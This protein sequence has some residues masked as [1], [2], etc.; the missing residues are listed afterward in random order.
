MMRVGVSSSHS[1]LAPSNLEGHLLRETYQVEEKIAHGG[2]AWVY[3]ARHVKEGS[4]W[5]LKI[6]FPHH[7]EN[8]SIRERFLRESKIQNQLA[9]PN[10][11]RVH[12]PIREKNVFGYAMEW[13]NGNDLRL[14]LQRQPALLPMPVMASLF[15]GIIEGIS[16]AHTR[17]I[18]H[19]D[20]KPE[21]VL[22]SISNG[23][24]IPRI[25][26]FGIA[27]V[28]EDT[29]HTETGSAIGT[30]SYM[31][32]EQ[33][34]DAKTI[35]HRSDIY[36]LGVM[37]YYM[38]TGRLPF[39]FRK[40]T[41]QGFL[42]MMLKV[43]HEQPAVPVEAPAA[44]QPLIMKCLEKQVDARFQSCDELRHAFCEACARESVSLR[45]LTV[46]DLVLEG[47]PSDTSGSVGVSDTRAHS[48]SPHLV[49]V[50]VSAEHTPA[51]SGSHFVGMQ[52]TSA[53]P[54]TH[55]ELDSMTT[56]SPG[57]GGFWEHTSQ[58]LD[59]FEG[60]LAPAGGPESFP[61]GA[62]F[63]ERK[64]DGRLVAL[65]LAGALGMLCFVVWLFV[66]MSPQDVG[67]LPPRRALAPLRTMPL[68][69]L[70]RRA[71]RNRQK[72][73]LL[74][75]V[76]AHCS[77]LKRLI[78]K[79]AWKQAWQFDRAHQ[80]DWA[81]IMGS[82]CRMRSLASAF[83]SVVLDSLRRLLGKT[84]RSEEQNAIRLLINWCQQHQR[85]LGVSIRHVH[86]SLW[87]NARKRQE[88]GRVQRA[89]LALLQTHPSSVRVHKVYHLY[90]TH[91]VPTSGAWLMALALTKQYKQS[92]KL[93]TT[94]GLVQWL[95]HWDTTLPSV[96]ALSKEEALFRTMS[97]LSATSQ[98]LRDAFQQGRLLQL[99]DFHAK[100]LSQRAIRQQK[101]L[102]PYQKQL[103]QGL[104]PILALYPRLESTILFYRGV[105]ASR[106]R[107][108][109]A[110]ATRGYKRLIVH[111]RGRTFVPQE[112]RRRWIRRMR[113]QMRSLERRVYLQGMRYMRRKEWARAKQMFRLYLQSFPRASRRGL[114]KKR[115]KRATTCAS[116][117]PW[118]CR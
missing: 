51:S 93:W 23:I 22:L 42:G 103:M 6:L 101:Q 66:W 58:S 27:K 15:L 79:R 78:D 73:L 91:Y 68:P 56:H 30:F 64:T 1:Y 114:V 26:D 45:R 115:L 16:F 104:K 13:C 109:I 21:N 82:L 39:P 95:R 74:P 88:F 83:P 41:G 38:T 67:T 46:A 2:M 52:P 50:E 33:F 28:M 87:P 99:E 110:R 18:V 65:I 24:V 14:L 108:Q 59:S 102:A 71:I 25:T 10:I 118:M 113:A 61:D 106:Q 4:L 60:P 94:S 31:S 81:G 85:P 57:P 34:L 5:A 111:I 36:S 77:T 47:F 116:S 54:D 32:P 89:L 70:Q 7:A 48:M 69:P 40:E 92:M 100:W 29:G 84:Q 9:H 17:G 20:M 19:R 105:T 80:A 63:A 90:R 107:G 55:D 112:L 11:V 86:D 3:R 62:V 75:S 35:D 98:G 43:Q 96:D 53:D 97:R 12:E 49:G 117:P 76:R 8:E 37:L 44:L 72:P